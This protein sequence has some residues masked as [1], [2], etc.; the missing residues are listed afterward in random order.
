MDRRLLPA[1]LLW[2]DGEQ[3]KPVV[4]LGILDHHT[5]RLL[6]FA[7]AANR[8]ASTVKD[9]LKAAIATFGLPGRF[10]HDLCRLRDYAD[11]F[12]RTRQ[13]A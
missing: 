11:R 12:F 1:P 9:G 4:I 6:S 8:Q 10:Y 13:I 7:A 2:R 3:Q 5:R